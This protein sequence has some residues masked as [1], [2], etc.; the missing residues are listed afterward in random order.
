[1]LSDCFSKELFS[2]RLMAGSTAASFLISLL[3]PPL[4]M[5]QTLVLPVPGMMVTQSPAYMP[6][7]TRGLKVH[8][9]NPLLFDFIV[10][11]GDSGFAV[12]GSQFKA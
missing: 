2:S 5:A 7:M 11:A 4:V 3:V 8:P 10:D 6:V 9:E 12:E 1:M